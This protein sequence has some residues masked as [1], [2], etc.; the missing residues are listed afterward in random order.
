M[1]P[2]I[3][4]AEIRVEGRIVS[5]MNPRM[6]YD[7][8]ELR[9]IRD[10]RRISI[11]LCR[12]TATDQRAALELDDWICEIREPER[13]GRADISLPGAGGPPAVG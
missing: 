3:H 4:S 7:E 6:D 13:R 8:V 11:F 10:G 1:D 9:A 2:P 12:A 5:T